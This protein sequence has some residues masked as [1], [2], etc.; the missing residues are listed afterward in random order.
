LGER[1][2]PDVAASIEDARASV[3]ASGAYTDVEFHRFPWSR[4]F[5][6]RQYVELLRTFSDV[7]TRPAQVR[8]PFLVD[9]AGAIDGAGGSITRYYEAMLM[10]ARPAK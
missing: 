5:D 8:E 4:S 2:P 1:D 9:I 6:T 10:L 3:E 7:S